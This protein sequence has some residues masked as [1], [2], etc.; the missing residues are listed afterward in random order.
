MGGH[1]SHA[2]IEAVAAFLLVV[3]GA[4]VL[5]LAAHQRRRAIAGGGTV[6]LAIRAPTSASTSV[7][8]VIAVALS[9]GAAVIHLAAGPAHV[10]ELGDLGLGFY[11]AALFQAGWAIAYLARPTRHVAAVGIAGSLAISA[12][13]AWSRAVGL[14]VG[15]EA[16]QPEAIGVPDAIAT[17]F[18]VLLAALL[19]VTWARAPRVAVVVGRLRPVASNLVTGVPVVG[20]VF[21]AT[22]LAVGSAGSGHGHGGPTESAGSHASA[23][24]GT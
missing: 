16:W 11:W 7:A 22:A 20:I 19:A 12:A 6:A 9:I 15:A 23:V 8:A 21:L 14:P 5:A 24:H 3:G 18:Q 17:A 2:A 1:G 4:V 13:W 10:E